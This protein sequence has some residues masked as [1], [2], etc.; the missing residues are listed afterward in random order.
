M[1]VQTALFVYGELSP[2]DLSR[3]LAKNV[4]GKLVFA[5]EI[6]REYSAS[7]LLGKLY[8]HPYSGDWMPVDPGALETSEWQQLFSSS[9]SLMYFE[10]T[11]SGKWKVL[12]LRIESDETGP[13]VAIALRHSE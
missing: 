10:M 12:H 5:I 13:Y 3:Y 7:E 2:P 6:L 4:P 9:S 8:R 1:S 11:G